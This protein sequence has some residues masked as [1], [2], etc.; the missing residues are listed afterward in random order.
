MNW[1]QIQ[2]LLSIPFQSHLVSTRVG[3]INSDGTKVNLL[4]YIDARDVYERL[5]AVVGPGGWSTELH[6]IQGGFIATLSIRDPETG[7]W[8]K[9]SDASDNTDFEATKGGAS[10]ATKRA[11]VLW[12]IGRY[13]Y[14]LPSMWVETSKNPTK[15]GVWFSARLKNGQVSEGYYV[16]PPLPYYAQHPSESLEA[17]RHWVKRFDSS[18]QIP[19]SGSPA[20]LWA[21][22]VRERLMEDK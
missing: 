19:N 18:Y 16:P 8:V 10:S 11:A 7:E 12:G 15:N 14:G 22:F 20:E 21:K 13:L 5:D 1:K 6:I 4:H 9:K 3:R 2:F 17:L